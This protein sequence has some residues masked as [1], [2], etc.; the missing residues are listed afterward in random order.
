MLVYE[1]LGDHSSTARVFRNVVDCQRSEDGK[2]LTQVCKWTF[3]VFSG[4]FTLKLAVDKNPA[5]RC[6]AFTI[7]ESSFMKGF[8]G[9]WQV[10]RLEGSEQGETCLVEHELSMK[11]LVPVPPPISYY[12]KSVL[13]KEVM[14]V[15]TDLQMEVQ[16]QMELLSSPPRDQGEQQ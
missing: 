8:E 14:T 1:I 16:H 10:S 15:L 9:R 11:P 2:S 12:T 3:S 4:S 6:I 13:E 5:Q 7:L